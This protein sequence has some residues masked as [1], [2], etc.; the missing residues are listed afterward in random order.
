[1]IQQL[2]KKNAII[3]SLLETQRRSRV[4]NSSMHDVLKGPSVLIFQVYI[5]INSLSTDFSS[6]KG[7]K[8]LPLNLQIDTYDFSSGTNQLI[9]RAA[10]QVKIFC[11]KVRHWSHFFLRGP[12][13][14]TVPLDVGE[15]KVLI[16]TMWLCVCVLRV[17]RGRCAMRRGREAR[18]GESPWMPIV[19]VNKINK[20][21]LTTLKKIYLTLC[22]LLLHFQPTS[23]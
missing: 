22:T 3:T 7:V 20:H 5:G 13:F 10:C 21:L 8:G 2:V 12:L 11:D 1:M 9:H 6:Q 17:R 15:V 23:L 14:D 16:I 4:N 19:S 18:G